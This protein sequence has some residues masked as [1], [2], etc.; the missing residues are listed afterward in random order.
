MPKQL[1]ESAEDT[2][3][4]LWNEPDTVYFEQVELIREELNEDANN[5]SRNE[6]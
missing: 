1:P 5:E 2:M 3:N 6:A 4:Q